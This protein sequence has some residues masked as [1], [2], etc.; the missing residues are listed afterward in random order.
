MKK[1]YL[2]FVLLTFIFGLGICNAASISVRAST[3]QVTVGSTFNVT[4][5]V[6][7]VGQGAGNVGAWKYCV[8]YNSTNL[9]LVSP[10]SPCVNDGVVGLK[11]ASA[12]YTF[13]A[14]T[15]ADNT[16][17]LSGVLL[18]DYESEQPMEVNKGSV[19]VRANL[20]EANKQ[21]NDNVNLSTNANLRILEVVGYTLTPE[22]SKDKT[23]YTLDVAGDVESVQ[24]NAYREDTTAQI[25]PIDMVNLTEG[26]N[27]VTVTVTAAKG[28]KKTY[29]IM[30]TRAEA[31]PVKV[32]VSGKEYSVVTKVGALDIP[33]GYVAT[34]VNIE[35]KDVTAYK[36]DQANIILVVLKDQDSNMSYFIYDEGEFT[37]YKQISSSSIT[38]VPKKAKELIK[39]YDKTKNVT[40]AEKDITVYYK[41]ENDNIVLIYG[42]NTISGEESWYYYDT[43][44]GAMLKYTDTSTTVEETHESKDNNKN[45]RFLLLALFCVS[46]LALLFIISLVLYVIKLKNKNEE[47]FKYMEKRITKHRDKKFN[48][49]VDK[50]IEK[51]DLES[52][53]EEIEPVIEEEV[54]T[55][56]SKEEKEEEIKDIEEDDSSIDKTILLREDEILDL[57]EDDYAEETKKKEK[58]PTLIS[59]TDI[60]RNIAKANEKSFDDEDEPKKVSKKEEKLLKKKKKALEKQAQREFLNDEVFEESAFDIYERDETEII[61]VVKKKTKARTKGRKKS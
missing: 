50:E 60:L 54:I 35:G 13:K 38:L 9:T 42:I 47:L 27:K 3:N 17:G 59:D 51:S 53:K 24:V 16:I 34:T 29:T 19:T 44:D 43:K 18:Y 6:N 28:N 21:I 32:N 48:S 52:F 20:Q 7:G 2:L 30:I 36:N 8:D 25:T 14:N 45:Y 56:D 11:Q 49:F 15:T 46:G 55:E 12:T 23:E 37:S 33:A 58:S 26:T 40:I 41:E 10:S 22:F 39:G 61:P 5:T 1:R 57:D 31:N 4:V